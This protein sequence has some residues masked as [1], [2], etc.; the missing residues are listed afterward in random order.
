MRSFFGQ[1]ILF[2][3]GILVLIGLLRLGI[4]F[5]KDTLKEG[6][7][8]MCPQCKKWFCREE[9]SSEMIDQRYCKKTVDREGTVNGYRM[10]IPMQVDVILQTFRH[11]CE[12]KKCKYK[13]YF[14]TVKEIVP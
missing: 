13:W 12:C 3:V 8:K 10:T 14:D 5:L 7:E 6:K 1:V 2:F 9:L 4:F 11:N